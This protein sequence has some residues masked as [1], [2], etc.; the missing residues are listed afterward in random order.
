M[1]SRQLHA[2]LQ[3]AN[4]ALRQASAAKA[5]NG[6]RGRHAAEPRQRS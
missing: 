6:A 3:M 5:T 1:A 4:E 2:Q